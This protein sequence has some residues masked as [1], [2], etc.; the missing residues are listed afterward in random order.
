MRVRFEAMSPKHGVAKA[1]CRRGRAQ[2]AKD[3]EWIGDA[4]S[5]GQ[6]GVGRGGTRS[7]A[8]RCG[9]VVGGGGGAA[10]RLRRPAFRSAAC[11]SCSLLGRC[12]PELSLLERSLGE[13]S[14][15]GSWAL[16]T[17]PGSCASTTG[18]WQR[19]TWRPPGR[20]WQPPWRHGT[21]R[22]GH[23]V[24]RAG[25]SSAS[26]RPMTRPPSRT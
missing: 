26:R 11:R 19:R 4:G 9:E 23:A 3:K 10:R 14:L 17:C 8:R 6:T 24:R 20:D 22:S 12:R 16:M 7:T 18:W 5:V 25:P 21:W 1:R 2:L 13:L 15:P